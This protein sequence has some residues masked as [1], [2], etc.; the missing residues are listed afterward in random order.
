M[1]AF[2][3]RAALPT[4]ERVQYITQAAH[5][6]DAVNAAL[7]SGYC[8]VVAHPHRPERTEA[9]GRARWP[10]PLHPLPFADAWRGWHERDEQGVRV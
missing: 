8:S 10:L 3:I 6:F 7:D 5:G 2:T 1:T 4:G 9:E